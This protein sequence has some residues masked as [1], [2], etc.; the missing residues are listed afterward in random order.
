[1]LGGRGK[2]LTGEGRVRMSSLV[3]A[4]RLGLGMISRAIALPYL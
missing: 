4:P 3:G 1:M 2:S